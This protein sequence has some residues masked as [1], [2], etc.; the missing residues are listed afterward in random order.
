M[1]RVD[2]E[3]TLR[4]F[5]TRITHDGLAGENVLSIT[6]NGGRTQGTQRKSHGIFHGTRT[7]YPPEDPITGNEI[8]SVSRPSDSRR[9]ESGVAADARRVAFTKEQ[10]ATPS[11]V[12]KTI[13][14]GGVRSYSLVRCA[15]SG[16]KELYLHLKYLPRLGPSV[17]PYDI[18]HLIL[19]HVIGSSWQLFARIRI[20]SRDPAVKYH[21]TAAD[22]D[23]IG[24]QIQSAKATVPGS[25]V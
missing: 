19:S 21:L 12:R 13:E 3:V 25:Q 14:N 2:G 4:A 10:G 17:V 9:T 22:A 16:D 8:F 6:G 20:V 18:M 1:A 23:A 24:Q 11:P 5:I 15:S 7:Y